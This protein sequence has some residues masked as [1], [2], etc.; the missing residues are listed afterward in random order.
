MKTMADRIVR[1]MSGDE[2]GIRT[3]R[4]G[5]VVLRSAFQLIFS[6]VGQELHA[7]AVEGLLRLSREGTALEPRPWVENLRDDER[8]YIDCLS[9]ALHLANHQ[10]IG[11]DGLHHIMMVRQGKAMAFAEVLAPLI[12]DMGLDGSRL[13]GAVRD[14]ADFDDAML[15]AFASR[16]RALG[17]RVAIGSPGQ[18]HLS[19]IR[20]VSPDIVSIEGAWFRRVCGNETATRLL[21][22]FANSLKAEGIQMLVEGIETRAQLVAALYVGA[23]LVS[24]FLLSRPCIVGTQLFPQTLPLPDIL[25]DGGDVVPLFGNGWNT[26]QPR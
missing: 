3:A 16:F 9:A 23:D 18:P 6:R 14:P 2:I 26:H 11:I 10:N 22:S 20:S 13:I 5:D 8:G 19:M 1:A 12:H 24:G 25:A 15:A 4:H 21:R 7:V 17:G